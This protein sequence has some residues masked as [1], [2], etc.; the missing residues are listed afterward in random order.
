MLAQ[1]PLLL[2]FVRRLAQLAR[3]KAY[4]TS[5][6]DLGRALLMDFLKNRAQTV[7]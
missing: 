5:A 2:S 7:H 6:A 4:L 1:D 3:G